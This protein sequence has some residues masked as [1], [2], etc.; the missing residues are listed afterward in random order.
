LVEQTPEVGLPEFL[1]GARFAAFPA[2]I[3]QFSTGVRRAGLRADSG[4]AL[5]WAQIW[6][7]RITMKSLFVGNMNFQT[8]EADLRA[9]VEPFGQVTR[10]HIAMDRETGRARGFAFIEM[11]NDDEAA[12]A[13]A[14]LDGKEMG[15]RNL[16]VNEA[17]PKGEGGPARGPRNFGGP[18]GG[19]GPGGGSGGGRGKG[20]GGG[21][22]RFSNE[23]YRESARQPR[24]PR[25]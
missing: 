14:G 22:D 19:R 5:G 21:R 6:M 20:G 2:W 12:K 3:Q 18:S 4:F 23:D 16:K 13:I 8:S 1:E 17:R 9:L 11:P 7:E 24:E 25:W 15:G 10:V